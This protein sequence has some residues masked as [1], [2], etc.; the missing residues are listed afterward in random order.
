VCGKVQHL[1]ADLKGKKKGGGQGLRG[2]AGDSKR[3]APRGD[4]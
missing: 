3:T 1:N 4:N 2:G